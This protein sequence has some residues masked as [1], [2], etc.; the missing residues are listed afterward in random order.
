MNYTDEIDFA[1]H[2]SNSVAGTRVHV[3]DPID[4]G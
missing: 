3:A 4:D 1:K 2:D